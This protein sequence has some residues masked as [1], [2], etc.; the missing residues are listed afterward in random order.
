MLV[1]PQVNVHDMDLMHRE[2]LE[3]LQRLLVALES[4][5]DVIVERR[6][7]ALSDHM[8]KHFAFEERLMHACH[9]PMQR[10]HKGEHDKTLN[11]MR[12]MEME[13]RTR[14]DRG[15]LCAYLDEEIPSGSSSISRRWIRR[16]PPLSGRPEAERETTMPTRSCESVLPKRPPLGTRVT[17]SS[18]DS[19]VSGFA[20]GC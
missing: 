8:Q 10:L 20:R 15:A 4:E 17:T 9:Y 3:V 19:D 13:W 1:L 5:D 7:D 12:M 6:F 2:E 14:R 16:W 11:R 18:G